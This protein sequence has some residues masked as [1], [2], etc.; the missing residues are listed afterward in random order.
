MPSLS[1]V[2]TRKL[3]RD[4]AVGRVVVGSGLVLAPRLFATAWVGRGAVN[5]GTQVIAAAMGARDL[6]I[7]LG[8]LR[9]VRTGGRAGPWLRAGVF[10]DI[11]DLVATLRARGELPTSAV[12]SVSFVAT[13]SA[14]VGVWLLRE[15]P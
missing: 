9:A 2:D 13:M 15:L 6:A 14:A 11:V 1:D 7:G 12:V 3:A 5:A 4:H 10:A 8:A